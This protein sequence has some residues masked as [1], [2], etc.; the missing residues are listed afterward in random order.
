MKKPNKIMKKDAQI[1][2]F[3]IIALLIIISIALIIYAN[4]KKIVQT[5]SLR[6]DAH[7]FIQQCARDAATNAVEQIIPNGGILN[8]AE[9]NYVA[10]QKTKPILICSALE[11]EQICTNY[12]PM[13]AAEIEK[14]IYDLIKPKIDACFS[15]LKDE[16]ES[17]EYN[18]GEINLALEIAPSKLYIKISKKISYVKNGITNNLENFNTQITSPLYDFVVISNDIVNQEV[19][20]DC[21]NNNCNANIMAINRDKRDYETARDIDSYNNKIYSIKEV[22]SGKEFNFAVRNCVRL[23]Y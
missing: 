11:K 9:G 5:V 15:Q 14:E 23:P 7:G 20:C 16:F 21:L 22:A 18:E 6:N 1:T 4:P 17:Y 10:W 3:V 12:H 8:P 2:I 13:L 19:N